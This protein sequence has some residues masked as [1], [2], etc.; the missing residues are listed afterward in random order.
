[1][2]MD[3][4]YKKYAN[5]KEV[6][7]DY[8]NFKNDWHINVQRHMA[9]HKSGVVLYAKGEKEHNGKKLLCVKRKIS[10]VSKFCSLNDEEF[11][12]TMA[13]LNAQFIILYEKMTNCDIA[14]RKSG[15]S[16]LN[17]LVCLHRSKYQK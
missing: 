3:K 11:E 8:D 4:M 14:N 9:V 7:A 12:K 5:K 1:M 15:C 17:K 6:L 2:M 10:N 16:L 13:C